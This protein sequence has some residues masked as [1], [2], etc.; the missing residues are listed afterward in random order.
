[1]AKAR[2]A[3]V[4]N[5]YIGVADAPSIF[6]KVLNK[7]S[8]HIARETCNDPHFGITPEHPLQ[9]AFAVYVLLRNSYNRTDLWLNG[10]PYR[11]GHSS[12]GAVVAY[13][14][15]QRWQANMREPFDCVHLNLPRS[16]LDDIA[17]EIGVQ[18]IGTLRLPPSENT[19]DPVVSGL[20]TGLLPALENEAC[21]SRLF[22]ESV[23]LALCVHLCQRYGGMSIDSRVLRGGLAPWQLK[24]A[25]EMLL[26]KIDGDISVEELAIACHV[27]RSHFARAFKI[28]TGLAPHQWLRKQRVEK[29]KHL[30]KYSRFTLA[31]I[32]LICGFVDQSHLT[33]VFKR[34]AAVNPGEYRRAYGMTPS[35]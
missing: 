33:R 29:A 7:S 1:M 31:E 11:R 16:V 17:D 13:P 25:Q 21:S 12:Q 14:L 27:S 22:I 2:S 8:I 15:D 19:L 4:P 6:V 32:A 20:I 10:K 34:D 30:L 5:S 18:R 24:H 35:P 9:D 26:E 28:S 3:T 23:S